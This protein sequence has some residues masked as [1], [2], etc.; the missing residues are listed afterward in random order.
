MAGFC[1]NLLKPDFEGVTAIASLYLSDRFKW[2]D[3][4]LS[5]WVVVTN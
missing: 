4:P 3:K 5:N 1:L 2:M